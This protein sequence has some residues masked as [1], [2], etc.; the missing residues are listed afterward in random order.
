MEIQKYYEN[1]PKF[2]DVYSRNSLLNTED[3]AYTINLDEYKST[4]THWIALYV[5]G[6][7]R[8][9]SYDVT[10]FGSFGVEYIPQ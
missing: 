10:Y 2:N 8:S 9:A 1:V 5:N 3:E 6:N 7:N 4:G